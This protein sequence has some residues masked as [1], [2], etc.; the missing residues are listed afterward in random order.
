MNHPPRPDRVSTLWSRNW[1]GS[2][3]SAQRVVLAL[4]GN[5]L[6]RRGADPALMAERGQLERAIEAVAAVAEHHT[7]VL[8]HGNG[9]QVGQLALRASADGPNAE[10]LDVLGA[11]TEGMIGYLLE[12]ELRTRLPDR[13]VVTLLTQV[14]VDPS[15]PALTKPTKPIGQVYE[16]AEAEQLRDERGWTIARDGSGWRRTVPSP[17]P[18]RFLEQDAITLLMDAGH[19]VVCGGG[20]GIP[21]VV[22]DD[23]TVEGI[24]A[25]IDK[26]RSA[27]LLAAHIGADLLVLL[28]DVGAIY[29]DWPEQEQPV[30]RVTPLELGAMGLP[31]GSM[32]PKAEA[33]AAFVMETGRRAAIGALEDAV[34]LVEGTTGTQVVAD[35]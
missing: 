18:Q 25:V 30:G 29:R 5:A 13:P 35:P 14:Q 21:V 9:P 10:T 3:S 2:S 4:G 16:R 34:A 15:D 17:L 8:T 27:A 11:E 26:D 32:L 12:R 19:L 23:G 28:T 1:R 20:G 22:R 7:V 31:E 6:L 33:A 24:E